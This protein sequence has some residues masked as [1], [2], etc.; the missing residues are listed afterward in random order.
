GIMALTALAA[1]A[2]G[3]TPRRRRALLLIGV[4][5]AALFYGDSVITPAISVLGASEGLEI[6][7]PALKAWVV[8]MSVAILVG[9]FLAQRHGTEH[10]GR[11]FGPVI[12]VSFA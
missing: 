7:A 11:A 2:A 4:F 1:Q 10:V 6:V 8:P 12:L 9:L 5:G 3:G